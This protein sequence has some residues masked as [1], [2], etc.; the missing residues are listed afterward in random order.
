MKLPREIVIQ[1]I[2]LSQFAQQGEDQRQFAFARFQAMFIDHAG[3]MQEFE[4]FMRDISAEVQE[5]EPM[6]WLI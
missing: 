3:H 1:A 5:M 2:A 4:Q 6:E